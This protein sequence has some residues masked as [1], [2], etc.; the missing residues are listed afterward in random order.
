[1]T[2]FDTTFTDRVLG[3]L[4]AEYG[5]TITYTVATTAA[6]TTMEARVRDTST[7]NH[8][9]WEVWV[10]K[11]PSDAWKGIAAPV[12]GDKI[13]RSDGDGTTAPITHVESVSWHKFR[14]R[15]ARAVQ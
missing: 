6:A 3:E 9:E 10:G 15:R 1:M 13:T 4:L 11:N 14:C 7:D 5:E 12:P 2:S 8:I